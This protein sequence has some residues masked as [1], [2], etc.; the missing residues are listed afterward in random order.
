MRSI[1][2]AI[3]LVPHGTSIEVELI[4]EAAALLD[5]VTR[6][7]YAQASQYMA[8]LHEDVQQNFYGCWGEQVQASAAAARWH[9]DAPDSDDALLLLAFAHLGEGWRLRGEDYLDA[10]PEARRKAF[11]LCFE[12]GH[13]AFRTLAA[14]DRSSA[15][16]LYGL[17]HCDVVCGIERGTRVARIEQAMAVAPFHTP[18]VFLAAKGSMAKWGGSDEQMW[19][20][21]RWISASAPRGHGA[22]VA[23]PAHVVEWMYP[24]MDDCDSL[25][26]IVA[27]VRGLQLG[28]WMRQALL[29][30]LDTDGA[31]IPQALAA[32][33]GRA[34]RQQLSHFALALYLTGAWEEARPV[35]QALG[36]KVPAQPWC[37]LSFRGTGSLVDRVLGEEQR[38]AGVAHDRVCRDLGLNPAEVC[39]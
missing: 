7:Q 6:Q 38:H 19:A 16:A 17:I 31:G 39:R 20:Y 12:R 4:A 11:P 26:A 34:W 33:K 30:W 29:D 36:G 21:L 25:L 37:G 10:I 13:A 3:G 8:A 24:L 35:M 28:G 23:V 27:Q 22:H 18:T 14:R 9:A 5:L 2:Q 1:F 15:M 32:R